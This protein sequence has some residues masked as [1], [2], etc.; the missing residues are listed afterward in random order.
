M[1]VAGPMDLVQ[2]GQGIV[3]RSPVFIRKEE[4][5]EF[6]GLVSGIIDMRRLLERAGIE[7]RD[8]DLDLAIRG[9]DGQ[10]ERGEV[11]WGETR[12]FAP[13]ASSIKMMVTF[14]SGSWQ[15]AAT[16]RGGWLQDRNMSRLIHLVFLVL[17][18]ASALAWYFRLKTERQIREVE[19]SLARSQAT[20]HLGMLWNGTP[21]R[22][23][24]LVRGNAPDI[25][26]GGR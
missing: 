5:T 12:L 2:G 26:G 8:H 22:P 20:A 19:E 17:F 1:V 15:L 11:F 7:P 3:G 13:L 4:R 21:D 18:S 16:P 24:D 23:H 14:P 10:G 6:W 25:R 9:R